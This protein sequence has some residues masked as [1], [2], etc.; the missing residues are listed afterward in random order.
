MGKPRPESSR[1]ESKKQSGS[2]GGGGGGGGENRDFRTPGRGVLSAGGGSS[3]CTQVSS[4]NY[5]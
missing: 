5:C 2:G 1:A 4:D 3:V